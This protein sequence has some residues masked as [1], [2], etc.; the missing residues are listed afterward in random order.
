MS[1]PF[2][3]GTVPG[4]MRPAGEKR[5]PTTA[6]AFPLVLI[7]LQCGMTGRSSAGTMQRP[8][9]PSAVRPQCAGNEL[10]DAAA[11]RIWG[12]LEFDVFNR[13]TFR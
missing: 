8:D 3:W 4:A 9:C 7:Q 2:A 10:T 1:S 6:G 5:P 13:H 11:Y 12:K